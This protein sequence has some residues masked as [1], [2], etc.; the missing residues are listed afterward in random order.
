MQPAAA[1]NAKDLVGSWVAVSNVSEQNGIKS[2][3]Y[4]SPPLGM[5]IFE[6][7]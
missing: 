6:T 7:T 2:E 5:L 3:P 4:G 1:R